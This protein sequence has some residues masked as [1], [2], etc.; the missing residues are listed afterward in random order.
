MT[1]DAEVDCIGVGDCENKTVKRSPLTSKNLNR[2][3]SY[4]TSKARLAFIQLRKTF[5]KAPILQHF[6][7]EYHIRIETDVSGYAIIGVFSQ[8][9]LDNLGQ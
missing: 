9:T 6:D 1:E 3:M 5:T 4:L 7:P 8:L 2:A